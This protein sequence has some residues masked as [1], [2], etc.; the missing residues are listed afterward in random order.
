MKNIEDLLTTNA[1]KPIKYFQLN[2]TFLIGVYQG[3]FSKYDILIKYRQNKPDGK[4]TRLRTPKHIHW[5]VDLLIKMSHYEK[6][7]KEFLDYLIEIWEATKPNKNE[8]ERMKALSIESF[9]EENKEYILNF[10]KLNTK[11]SYSIKFLLTLAKLLMQQ[12]KNNLESAY[13]FKNLL[14][15]L[16]DGKDIY[17]IVYIATHNR[18]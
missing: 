15:G 14:I 18:R 11:G 1:F 16:K 7:T 17:K 9:L 4:W 10:E 8:I 13:F 2:N 6:L 5:A 3:S 12:E